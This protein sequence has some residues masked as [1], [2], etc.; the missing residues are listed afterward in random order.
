M[1][2]LGSRVARLELG[3]AEPQA[4][5]VVVI[6]DPGFYQNV[7]TLPPSPPAHVCGRW[8]GVGSCATCEAWEG[9]KQ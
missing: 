3:A 2:S 4:G 7:G 8:Y 1:G 9:S 6:D 5:D